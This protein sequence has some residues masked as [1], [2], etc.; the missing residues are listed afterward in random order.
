M[1]T[2]S[3]P[4]FT[5]FLLAFVERFFFVFG[6]VGFFLLIAGVHRDAAAAKGA[7]GA[8][9]TLLTQPYGHLLAGIVALGLLA[10]GVYSLAEARFRQLGR[11]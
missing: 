11:A 3:Q 2:F 1:S 7:G 10:F 8:V 9:A 4:A 6:I 5:Q